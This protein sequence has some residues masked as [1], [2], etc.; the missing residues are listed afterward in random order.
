[1]REDRTAS[2]KVPKS[3]FNVENYSQAIALA[4]TLGMRP[5]MAHCRLGLGKLYLKTAQQE[6]ARTELSAAM[7]R[8]RAMAMT[9]WLP[10]A[11]AALAEVKG[12]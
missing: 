6:Q 4:D 7:A 2:P 5:L 1:V 12:R 9:F 8:Y 3:P 10:Q 11:E